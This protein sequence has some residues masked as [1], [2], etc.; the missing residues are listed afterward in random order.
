MKTWPWIGLGAVALISIL[1]ATFLPPDPAHAYW[2]DRIPGF[3]MLYGFAGCVLIILFSKL[4]GKLFLQRK[5]DY[6]DNVD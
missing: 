3:Y 4:L 6:Y 1:V 2:W 5:E